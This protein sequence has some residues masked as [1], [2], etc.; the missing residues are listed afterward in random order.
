M[1]VARA[2][3]EDAELLLDLFVRDAGVVGD[4]APTCAAQLV[5][6][7]ARLAKCKAVRPAQRG[8]NVLDDPPILPR[9]SRRIDRLVDL[10]HSAFDLRDRAFIFF[11]Q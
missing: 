10:D 5:E 4:A 3:P 1:V 9:I 2:W 11:L 6:D 8:G 7:F